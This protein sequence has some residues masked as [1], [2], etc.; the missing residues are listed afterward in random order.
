MLAMFD[1]V[2]KGTHSVPWYSYFSDKIITIIHIHHTE[3][4]V[5]P[6][7]ILIQLF[8]LCVIEIVI[9]IKKRTLICIL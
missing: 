2:V 1:A 3:E 8:K 9:I 6:I 5:Q 4:F 7:K